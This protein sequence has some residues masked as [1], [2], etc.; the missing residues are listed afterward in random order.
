[1]LNYSLIVYAIL[2]NCTKFYKISTFQKMYLEGKSL[3]L[4][5]KQ[6]IEVSI[7]HNFENV[8]VSKFM[9]S[10]EIRINL[11]MNLRI[12]SQCNGAMHRSGEAVLV[13]DNRRWLTTRKPQHQS[14][15]SLR[16]PGI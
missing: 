12:V 13:E 1:M 15:A 11:G 6:S 7:V 5:M 2:P 4:K 14:T 9:K 3:C 10:L 16:C 8:Y